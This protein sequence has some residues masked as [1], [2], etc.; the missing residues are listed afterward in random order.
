LNGPSCRFVQVDICD[1]RSV[2]ACLDAEKP[3]AVLHLAAETHVDRS[4]EQ[5][6][7]FVRTNVVGTHRLLEACR[8]HLYQ[9]E[10]PERGQ[11]RFVHVS[12]DE[13]YGSLG[14]QGAFSEASPL[15]PHSPYAAS[16]AA[17]EQLVTAWLHT[18]GFPAIITRCSNNY[19]PYQLPEKFIPLMIINGLEGR[20]LPIYGD[21]T[22]IRD[23]LFVEDHVRALAAIVRRGRTGEIY[24]I[25][26]QS[27]R[28]NLAVAQLICDLID[29][30]V[31]A[32]YARRG[33][34]EFVQDRP[35]HDL[36]YALNIEKIERDLGWRASETFESGIAKT[37]KWYLENEAWWKPIFGSGIGA[38]R[39]GL[40]A[41]YLPP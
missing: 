13:V 14:P 26:G 12:T 20:R 17:A 2:R 10:P 39:L 7:D 31:P 18:Y 22:N 34:V 25:G 8:E 1:Q 3:A 19:G 24:N 32:S 30:A 6:D 35:G 27:E 4:I 15:Q 28:S 40:V 37:V 29:R 36:R 9:L 33:L 41:P 16:K 38:S 5:S 11:F 21:G 23:W